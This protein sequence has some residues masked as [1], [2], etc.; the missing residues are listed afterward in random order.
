MVRATSAI[1]PEADIGRVRR[2][3]IAENGGNGGRNYS[4]HAHFERHTSNGRHKRVRHTSARTVRQ[5]VAD[6]R[7]FRRLQQTT[8]PPRV[9]H[10]GST[11]FGFA[12]MT[13]RTCSAKAY[14]DT[15]KES[16]VVPRI[17]ASAVSNAN[18]Y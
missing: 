5:N 3:A 11:I 9:I 18:H 13:W 16:E 4:T 6:A 7:S 1:D 14:P 12:V 17:A 2:S 15:S 10:C 8:Y